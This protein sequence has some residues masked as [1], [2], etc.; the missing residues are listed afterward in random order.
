MG[1]ELQEVGPAWLNVRWQNISFLPEDIVCV[2]DLTREVVRHQAPLK[3]Q[4]FQAG[5]D[6]S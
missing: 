1:R 2:H 3:H 4:A 6:V 5:E